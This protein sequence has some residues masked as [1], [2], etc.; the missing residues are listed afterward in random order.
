MKKKIVLLVVAP[1]HAC[2]IGFSVQTQLEQANSCPGHNISVLQTAKDMPPP[3]CDAAS[4]VA[5]R[6]RWVLISIRGFDVSFIR[7]ELHSF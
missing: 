6:T 5:T 4:A 2:A 1:A 3:P 7:V